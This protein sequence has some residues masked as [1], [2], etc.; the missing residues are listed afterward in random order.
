[1]LRRIGLLGR[2]RRRVWRE[3][4][5]VKDHVVICGLGQIGFRS[6]ELL[7]RVGKP[8]AVITDK[9]L[10][11]WKTRVTA[12]GGVLLL[13]DARHDGL[14]MQAGIEHAS[15]VL[16]VTDQ[17]LVNISVVMD[18]RRLNPRI[19]TVCRL[20]D[21]NLGVQLSDAL[22]ID[23]VLSASELAAPVFVNAAL[24]R[25]GGATDANA[26]TTSR[27]TPFILRWILRPSLAK[28]RRAV[29]FTLSMILLASLIVQARMGLS[30]IDAMY[31]V[32]TTITTVGYGDFNFAA[33]SG[34]MKLF[35][36]G[37]ML[38]GAASLT[39]LFSTLADAFLSERFSSL[40][41]GR[42]VPRRHHVI[43]S[44]SGHIGARVVRQLTD[45]RIPVVVI[46][47]DQAGRCPPELRRQV[48]VVQGDARN[49][50]TLR[51]ANAGRARAIL[52][53]SDDDVENL[54]VGL[55]VQ[56]LNPGI[57]AVVRV[58]DAD[59]SAKLQSRLAARILSV[60]RIASPY[61]AAAALAENDQM[62]A[63]WQARLVRLSES[64][65]GAC[66]TFDA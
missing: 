49:A 11:D 34:G 66:V 8:A 47:S 50:E 36:I 17:D 19:R 25:A 29:L 15:A 60:S 58:F 51:R 35:G 38:L 30:W 33:A 61:F 16:A 44:G 52:A 54:S 14:L 57:A 23:H 39:L 4:R 37:L 59:I 5:L 56:H 53:I 64:L 12:T 45:L 62:L 40:F 46:E 55:S 26:P 42:H 7:H 13:G 3:L 41:G 31:F 48:A 6:Y 27:T 2:L 18:A 21:R 63:D 10:D 65:F 9:T 32:T 43:V 1:M 28:F 22:G 20:F 24:S